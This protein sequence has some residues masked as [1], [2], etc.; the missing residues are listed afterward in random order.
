MLCNSSV[1]SLVHQN[2]DKVYLHKSVPPFPEIDLHLLRL[3]FLH[4]SS[5]IFGFLRMLDLGW[6]TQV[7]STVSWD[8]SSFTKVELYA[9]IFNCLWISLSIFGCLPMLDLG[10]LQCTCGCFIKQWD[11]N[12]TNEYFIVTTYACCR[13][14]EIRGGLETFSTIAYCS[15][16]E[17]DFSSGHRKSEHYQP[18]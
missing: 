18:L 9:C 17:L 3:N 1:K 4:A 15:K 11:Q 7:C 5:T 10:W 8:W 6:L 16:S 13:A 14:I 2:S 12:L